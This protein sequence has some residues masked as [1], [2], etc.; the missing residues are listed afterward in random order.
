M[1]K[2]QS[3]ARLYQTA[4]PGLSEAQRLAAV[5]EDLKVQAPVEK[6][7]FGGSSPVDETFAIYYRMMV[8]ILM[9]DVYKRQEP[10][11]WN[12]C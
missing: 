6:K 8:Y 1:Y 7:R 10:Y 9:V 4:L 3:S 2:R 5:S 11:R 12:T